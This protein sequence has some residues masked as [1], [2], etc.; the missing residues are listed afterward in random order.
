ML[1]RTLTSVGRLRRRVGNATAPREELI[2]HYAR[3]RT[4][5]DI[6][7]MWKVDG[8]LCFVAEDASARAVTGVVISFDQM[9]RSACGR[10]PV[11]AGHHEGAPSVSARRSVGVTACAT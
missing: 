10:S 3:G 1:G 6:G 5:L 8:A 2:A 9:G 11:P 4:F 7:C